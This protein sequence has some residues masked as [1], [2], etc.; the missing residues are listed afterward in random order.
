MEIELPFQPSAG[1]NNQPIIPDVVPL[2]LTGEIN[3][4]MATDICVKLKGIET[5][6]RLNNTMIPVELIIN[7]PGGDLFAS[8]MVCDVMNSM[9]TPV[10]TVGMGQVASGGLLIFMNGLKG[11]RLT[12]HN[13]QFMSHRFIAASEA[14][15]Q[16]LKQQQG[17]WDRTHQ[18]IIDHYKLCTGLPIRTIEK[19]LLPEHNVWLTADDCLRYKICD[20]ID[21]DRYQ[22]DEKI[23]KNK[24]KAKKNVV[25]AR[26]TNK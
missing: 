13:T 14:S 7:S 26:P 16:D 11:W 2:F 9:V 17:E 3:M 23:P 15:H 24:R 20:K 22:P 21:E 19:E 10:Q 8:W 5:F 25:Q 12:T 6:N 1:E 18:R 4:A